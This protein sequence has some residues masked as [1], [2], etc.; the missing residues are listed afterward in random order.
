MS[1]VINPITDLARHPPSFSSVAVGIP[2]AVP[3][4]TNTETKS[5]IFGNLGDNFKIDS[6][7]PMKR[8]NTV[9]TTVR[10]MFIIPMPGNGPDGDTSSVFEGSLVGGRANDIASAPV[11]GLKNK[12]MLGIDGRLNGS[13]GRKSK[14]NE[15]P[16]RVD[17]R[18]PKTK[19]G[20]PGSVTP[21]NAKEGD[22]QVVQVSIKLSVNPMG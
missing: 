6:T 16:A 10:A 2:K 14:T 5:S 13:G 18:D 9:K 21:G 12:S 11:I 19:L 7:I 8:P 15:T 4:L 17:R 22:R 3:V 20:N 1:A